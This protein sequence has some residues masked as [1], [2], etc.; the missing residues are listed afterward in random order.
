MRQIFV[1]LVCLALVQPVWSSTDLS[2]LR[3][4]VETARAGDHA[5]AD[6]QLR[7]AWRDPTLRVE[8][9]R[10]L[11]ELHARRDFRLPI[12]EGQVQLTIEAIGPKFRRYE[13]EHFVVLSDCSPAW[14]RSKL[15]LLERARHQFFRFAKTVEVDAVPHKHKLLCVMF[16]SYEAYRRFAKTHDGLDAPWAGGYY[17]VATNRM[18]IYDDADSPTVRDA[19]AEIT[20]YESTL[21]QIRERGFSAQ[22]RG[23]AARAR[24]LEA[25]ARD[26]AKSMQDA[27]RDIEAHATT[28]SIDKA[29]HEAAHM[30][31]YNTQVQSRY[32]AY[33]FW[34]TEGLAASFEPQDLN[35]PFGPE[36]PRASRVESFLE[37]SG[38]G[39]LIPW[40]AL[41][42][43]R[44]GPMGDVRQGEALYAQSAMLFSTLY[45]TRR[46]EL[47]A[48]LVALRDLP[49]GN[50]SPAIHIDLFTRHFGRIDGIERRIANAN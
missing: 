42:G 15:S 16:S 18:V 29:V 9:A 8:A 2:S 6:E 34:L 3:A 38:E 35:K 22:R 46:D 1:W 48:Y 26:L 12:E 30:L 24:A 11:H 4:A 32:R 25:Q 14:T 20:A 37:I 43:M 40:D 49:G 47:S 10:L 17:A 39:R 27:K 5:G 36:F 45:R 31:A 21:R 23:D 19:M 41:V 50:F 7:A 28:A 44:A 13:T 33:P